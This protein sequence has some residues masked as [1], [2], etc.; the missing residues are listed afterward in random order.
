M[1]VG[2]AWFSHYVP[3]A[4]L[5]NQPCSINR[6]RQFAPPMELLTEMEDLLHCVSN[7]FPC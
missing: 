6:I 7:D 2:R 5:G 4:I 3:E 1:F